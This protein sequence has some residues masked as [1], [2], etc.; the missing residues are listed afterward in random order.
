[1]KDVYVEWLV[2]KKRSLTDKIIRV[3]IVLMT[4]A[5]GLLALLS[6]NVVVFVVTLVLAVIAMIAFNYTDV[7]FEYIYV[8]G[9][10]GVDRILAKSKRKRIATFDTGKVEIIAPLGSHQLDGHKHKKY[11]VLD[12][13][14]GV[15]TEKS[16]IFVMY[17]AE[18]KKVL[19]EPNRELMT[20]LKGE[21]YLKVHIES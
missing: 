14:T 7:E 20:A 12:F 16:H 2:P 6:L 17:Y 8:N 18:G 13:T 5:C 11:K 3:T 9:E 1:M 4:V 19:L 21:M 15:R 10:L